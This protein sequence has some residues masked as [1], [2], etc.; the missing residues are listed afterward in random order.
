MDGGSNVT[1]R[2]ACSHAAAQNLCR[3]QAIYTG[4]VS[5]RCENVSALEDIHTVSDREP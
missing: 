2:D 1:A 3:I 4:R 5:R